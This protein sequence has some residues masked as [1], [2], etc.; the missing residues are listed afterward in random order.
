M[1]DTIKKYLKAASEF[2]MEHDDAD[3]PVDPQ[4]DKNGKRHISIQGILDEQVRWETIKD[5][6]D[7]LDLAM[8]EFLISQARGHNICSSEQAIVDW[9]VL[10]FHTGFRR[11]EYAQDANELNKNQTYERAKD[12]KAR[13]FILE[14]FE[15]RKTKTIR[16]NNA[17]QHQH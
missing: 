12:N 17:P 11:N 14:D 9:M 7:P 6:K 2:I 1:V 13:A 8:I 15:F 5:K 3:Q 4:H 16:L 10:G